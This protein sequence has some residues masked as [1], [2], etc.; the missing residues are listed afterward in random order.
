MKVRENWIDWAK[1][2]GIMLVIMGHY[3]MGDK[4]YGTFIYAFHM[5]LFFIVSGYLFTPPPQDNSYK[6]FVLK[7]VRS[8][9]VPYFIFGIFSV[10]ASAALNFFSGGDYSVSF[11]MKSFAGLVLGV[12]YDT[13]YTVMNNMPLWFLPAMF[14]VRV[15]SGF[16][17]RY[18]SRVKIAVCAAGLII[19][20]LL[21]R[22]GLFLPFSAGSALLALPFFYAGAVAKRYGLLENFRNG[23]M[24]RLVALFAV[25]AFVL[26]LSVYFNT[27]IT[28]INSCKYNN[29]LLMF[30]GGISGTSAVFCVC[31]AFD[32]IRSKFI[33]AVSDGTLMIM[34][35]HVY[36]ITV[37]WN[38][39]KMIAG[40]AGPGDMDAFVSLPAAVV[41]AMMITA[42]LYYPIVF[43]RKRLPL[44]L[45][46]AGKKTG[47]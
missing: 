44:L 3:G 18:K 7:N 17:S 32:G 1:S 9:I 8:L 2:I 15:I 28:D 33:T 45:G 23:E 41:T 13:E 30:T 42:G 36:G 11:F 26:Y 19:V 6:Q 20:V 4:I 16:L 25:S 29:M 35:L 43:C 12:G 47:W 5:P 39:Y 21:H 10:L 38:F 27:G 34:S 37:V 22:Y 24:L 46:K 14:F 31:I 40:I